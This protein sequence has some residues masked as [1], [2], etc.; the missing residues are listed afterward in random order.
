MNDKKEI[1]KPTQDLDAIDYKS[2]LMKLVV[3]SASA[4]LSSKKPE[5]AT[6]INNLL[7]KTEGLIESFKPQNPM[8][9]MLAAQMLVVHELQQH[10]T[11]YAKQTNHP[12]LRSLHVKDVAKLANVF[13]R[14]VHTFEK[15]QG[16]GNQKIMVEHVNVH[17]GAQAIVGSV[18]NPSQE[19]DS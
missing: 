6:E 8:Q 3:G 13:L 4:A 18:I 9:A 2:S 15:M 7:D 11:C 5:G 19:K 14:Q 12:K 1:Q 17:P 10:H 16:K